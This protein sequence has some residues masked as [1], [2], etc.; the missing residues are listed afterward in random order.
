MPIY[1]KI[2]IRTLALILL[3]SIISN[4]VLSLE[5]GN[6]NLNIGLA[7]VF[8]FITFSAISAVFYRNIIDLGVQIRLIDRSHQ[9]WKRPYISVFLGFIVSCSLVFMEF[10]WF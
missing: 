5:G 8:Y 9:R 1:Q 7:F 6:K 3:I 10:G 2:A 4:I